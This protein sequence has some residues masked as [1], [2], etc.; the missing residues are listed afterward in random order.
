MM[1]DWIQSPWTQPF[2]RRDLDEDPPRLVDLPFAFSDADAFFARSSAA[3]F[4]LAMVAGEMREGKWCGGESEH[5]EQGGRKQRE[6]GRML[7]RSTEILAG[8]IYKV[9]S[10]WMTGGPGRSNHIQEQLCRRDTWRRKRR[11]DRG[12]YVPSH[13]SATVRS[14]SRASPNFAS[15]GIRER[16]IGLS[17]AGFPAI[18]RSEIVEAR[19]ITRRKKRM[20]RVD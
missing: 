13:P 12:V 7:R 5:A 14:A 9:P 11:G 2:G 4:S 1:V 8:H 3:V 16:Q 20:D 15:R 17:D 19:K 6:R 10:E 18:R